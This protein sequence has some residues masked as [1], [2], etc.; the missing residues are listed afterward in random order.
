MHYLCNLNIDY[1]TLI[2][3]PE[4]TNWGKPQFN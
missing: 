1:Q 2:T 4:R 3:F